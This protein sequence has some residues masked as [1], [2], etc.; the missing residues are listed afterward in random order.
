[1][2]QLITIG[3]LY[4]ILCV[5]SFD[6]SRQHH[7]FALLLFNS[8]NKYIIVWNKLVLLNVVHAPGF[9]TSIF[10]IICCW[11][12][13]GPCIA[14]HVVTY[15]NA[16]FVISRYVSSVLPRFSKGQGAIWKGHFSAVNWRKRA[17]FTKSA[18]EWHNKRCTAQFTLCVGNKKGK[19]ELK[20]VWLILK[21][22]IIFFFFFFSIR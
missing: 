20:A 17:L 16:P 19:T 11:D 6:Q 10:H 5:C 12:Y 15:D 3:S 21:I 9:F 14:I 4:C 8:M 1:M 22:K 13:I 18:L 2:N 7:A